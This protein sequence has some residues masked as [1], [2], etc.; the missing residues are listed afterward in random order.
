MLHPVSTVCLPDLFKAHARTVESIFLLLGSIN[1]AVLFLGL[2]RFAR[3]SSS[4]VM[5]RITDSE[6]KR[7]DI[8]RGLMNRKHELT[9]S[10]FAGA[11]I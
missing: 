7:Q 5:E 6:S 10:V 4:E 9:A 3:E 2:L 1:K 8:Q 11:S